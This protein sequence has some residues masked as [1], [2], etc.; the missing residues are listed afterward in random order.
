MSLEVEHFHNALPDRLTLK[1]LFYGHT[2]TMRS[3]RTVEVID[4]SLEVF[5]VAQVV[6]STKSATL[7]CVPETPAAIAGVMRSVLW[8]FTKL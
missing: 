2:F 3:F 7:H 5:Y 6:A 1:D 4:Y 8:R